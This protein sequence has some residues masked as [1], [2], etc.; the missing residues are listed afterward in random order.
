[1]EPTGIAL[2]PKHIAISMNN[3]VW[4]YEIVEMKGRQCEVLTYDMTFIA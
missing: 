1:M 2:G 4:L 3:R